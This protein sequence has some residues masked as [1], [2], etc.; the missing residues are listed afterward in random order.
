M[1]FLGGLLMGVP[2][3]FENRA[4]PLMRADSRLR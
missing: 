4:A 1:V 3:N 2:T